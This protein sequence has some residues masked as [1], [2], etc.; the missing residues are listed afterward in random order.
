MLQLG[1]FFFGQSDFQPYSFIVC[2]QNNSSIL[3]DSPYKS[4]ITCDA[5]HRC[6]Q[7]GPFCRHAV[8]PIV[9]NG[10]PAS[11]QRRYLALSTAEVMAEY[12]IQ[13][14]IQLFWAK[15]EAGCIHNHTSRTAIA[16]LVSVW[17]VYVTGIYCSNQYNLFSCR[18][19]MK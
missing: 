7:I 9:L 6:R 1:L 14:V 8:L 12:P 19:L 13:T 2:A 11:F 15:K 5:T 17:I 4:G 10:V 16:P 18:F 3:I